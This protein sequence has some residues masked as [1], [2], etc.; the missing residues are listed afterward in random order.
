[1]IHSSH[2]IAQF[3]FSSS[4]IDVH[5]AALLFLFSIRPLAAA[6]ARSCFSR[7]L[8][9][10][11]A[12]ARCSLFPDRRRSPPLSQ[13]W[14]SGLFSF[15]LLLL[16][17]AVRGN[18]P[19]RLSWRPPLSSPFALP[20]LRPL[21]APAAR[22]RCSRPLLWWCSLPP[23]RFPSLRP[24][25]APAACTR[26]VR[27]L[28]A[29]AACTRCAR[30]LL[31]PRCCGGALFPLCASFLAPA[32]CARC[33][34]PLLAPAAVVVLSSPFALPSLRPLRAPAAR[35]RCSRPLLW[36]CVEAAQLAPA[37]LFPLCASFSGG[38]E[39]RSILN[40]H[41][42]AARRTYGGYG[43][44]FVS[45]EERASVTPTRRTH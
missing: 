6:V 25:R 43:Q 37:P 32:A 35:A 9:R 7:S 12:P 4:C 28:R 36:W 13:F 39:G 18:R 16:R 41:R 22:A 17:V 14:R 19:R 2:K 34:R 45:F 30:P 3:L 31:A 27:P 40:I 29:P 33:A 21:R 8:F 15:L 26:C 24:L 44:N 20:S 23:L 42:L 11:C 5:A 1:M 38:L 10:R